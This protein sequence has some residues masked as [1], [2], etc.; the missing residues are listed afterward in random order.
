MNVNSQNQS[1][2]LCSTSI[3]ITQH[4]KRLTSIR[5]LLNN[6]LL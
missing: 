2:V 4:Y 5:L 1:I 6:V 3:I